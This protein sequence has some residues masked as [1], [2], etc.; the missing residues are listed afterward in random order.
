MHLL[1]PSCA[2]FGISGLT[3]GGVK[4]LLRQVPGGQ[5]L[6][7]AGTGACLRFSCSERCCVLFS[8]STASELASC[9]SKLSAILRT[10]AQLPVAKSCLV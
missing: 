6:T 4:L 7:P 3:V 2:C 10:P 5:T 1:T 8:V 9:G